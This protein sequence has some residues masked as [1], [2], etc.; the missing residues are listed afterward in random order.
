MT[1]FLI[2]MLLCIFILGYLVMC[3]LD[4]FFDKG[5][6]IDSPKRRE[7]Q[8]VMVYGAS[9]VAQKIRNFGIKCRV[10]TEPVFPNDGY[11]SALFALSSDDGNNLL[12]CS[13]TKQEEPGVC[14]IVRSNSSQSDEVFKTAGVNFILG[15]GEPIDGLLTEMW[16]I[17]K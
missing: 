3:R 4:N 15:P 10:L 7:N 11:Y 14:V 9:D 5:G 17:G 2:I 12:I 1:V 8:G 6:I 13:A 16:G